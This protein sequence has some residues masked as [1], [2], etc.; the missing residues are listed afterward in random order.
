MDQSANVDSDGKMSS[1]KE[2]FRLS[3]IKKNFK[4]KILRSLM[5]PKRRYI[6]SKLRPITF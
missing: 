3:E 2:D 1:L 5:L 6:S 4:I